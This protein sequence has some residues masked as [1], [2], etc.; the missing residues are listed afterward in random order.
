MNDL[1]DRYGSIYADCIDDRARD[2]CRACPGALLGQEPSFAI[3]I[4]RPFHWPLHINQRPFEC[5][6][7]SRVTAEPIQA[8]ALRGGN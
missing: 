1:Q 6:S 2:S 8:I 7:C 4:T 5:G 3:S